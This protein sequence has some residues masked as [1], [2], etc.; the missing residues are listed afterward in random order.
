MRQ[1][2]VGLD[3]KK[4]FYHKTGKKQRDYIGAP[5]EQL[6]DRYAT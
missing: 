5:A 6:A 4:I 3:H 1:V 2:E